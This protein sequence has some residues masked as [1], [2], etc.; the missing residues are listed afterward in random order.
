MSSLLDIYLKKDTIAILLD[1]LQKK[2]ENGVSITIS[3]SDKSNQYGNNVSAYV[4]QS[5]EERENKKPKFYV[6]NGK[7]FYTE[8]AIVKGEKPAE[9]APEPMNETDVK[10]PF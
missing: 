1:T 10:L 9:T 6:G 8:G 4:A 5:K 7:V 3:V 2:G